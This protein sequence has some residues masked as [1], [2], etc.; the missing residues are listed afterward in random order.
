MVGMDQKV[1]YVYEAFQQRSPTA[2]EVQQEVSKQVNEF[3]KFG[4]K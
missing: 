1:S 4:S 2:V 3:E